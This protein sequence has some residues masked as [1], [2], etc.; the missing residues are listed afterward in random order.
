[1]VPR[2]ISLIMSVHAIE[3]ELLASMRVGRVDTSHESIVEKAE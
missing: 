1:M 3:N 2:S